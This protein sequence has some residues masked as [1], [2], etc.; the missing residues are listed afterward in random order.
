MLISLLLSGFS[1]FEW[2]VVDTRTNT[3]LGTAPTSMGPAFPIERWDT[4]D[5]P[6]DLVKEPVMYFYGELPGKVV[7]RLGVN[8][9]KVMQA[10]PEL[11]NS[12]WVVK[13]AG[14]ARAADTRWTDAQ[15]LNIKVNG[16]LVGYIFY[17]FQ[18]EA[19]ENRVSADLTPDGKIKVV[20]KNPY[21]VQDVMCVVR[22]ADDGIKAGFVKTLNPG[23]SIE[24]SPCCQPEEEKA[25][26]MLMAMGFRDGAA[27]AF[28]NEWW[29]AFTT[30]EPYNSWE[31]QVDR[32]EDAKPDAVKGI[33]S[34][35]YRLPQSEIEKICPLR[36]N[37]EPDQLVRAWWVLV[38]P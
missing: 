4:D 8:C 2:G 33:V 5:G 7:V 28:V 17:E 36:I 27:R 9:E 32:P 30:G 14:D 29:L 13:S 23:Q 22:D 25:A 15:A 34:L 11:K 21:P 38:K 31:S 16:E 35:V 26:Q 6:P 37:P 20:N 3:V 24:V 12:R 18:A 1:V 19:F 10:I